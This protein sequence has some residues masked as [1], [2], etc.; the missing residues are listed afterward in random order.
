MM[1]LIKF[2]FVVAIFGI[3]AI[4]VVPN[5]I[6]FVDEAKSKA[7]SIHLDNVQTVASEY[8]EDAVSTYQ[9]LLDSD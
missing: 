1:G 7:A 9:Q 4:L 8:I 5:V 3:I 6:N 2:L